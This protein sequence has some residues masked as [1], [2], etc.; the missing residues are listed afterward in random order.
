M[1]NLKVNFQN[2]IKKQIVIMLYEIRINIRDHRQ[3]NFITRILD[4]YYNLDFMKEVD[5]CLA[6]R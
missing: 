6:Q 4:K 5:N 3:T 2:V 1:A